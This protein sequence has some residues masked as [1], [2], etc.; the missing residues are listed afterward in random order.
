ML[1]MTSSGIAS[2]LS[3][4]RLPFPNEGSI[5]AYVLE[6]LGCELGGRSRSMR[7]RFE[8]NLHYRRV[9]S[10]IFFGRINGVSAATPSQHCWLAGLFRF[11]SSAAFVNDISAIHFTKHLNVNLT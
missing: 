6:S 3:G 1:R 4:R 9:A 10:I 8:A 5:V 7:R 2:S 11:L